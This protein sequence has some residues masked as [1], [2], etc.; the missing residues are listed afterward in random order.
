MTWYIVFSV[1]LH[2]I[3]CF[4]LGKYEMS[5]KKRVKLVEKFLTLLRSQIRIFTVV[6]V[7]M[8]IINIR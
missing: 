6:C 7:P 8:L 2:I 5:L 3:S 1:R 4:Y